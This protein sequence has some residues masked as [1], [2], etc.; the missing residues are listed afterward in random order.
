M[1]KKKE[2]ALHYVT[3]CTEESLKVTSFLIHMGPDSHLL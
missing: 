2:K 1:E 3:V